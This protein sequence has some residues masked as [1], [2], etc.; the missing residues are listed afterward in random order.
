M[1]PSRSSPNQIIS[2]FQLITESK[3]I[4]I[5]LK[6]TQ[7]SVLANTSK[8]ASHTV[9]TQTREKHKKT[10]SCQSISSMNIGAKILKRLAN[11]IQ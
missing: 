5:P 1:P 6:S 2:L 10:E 11:Q 7:M 8:K 9:D 3:I 4:P